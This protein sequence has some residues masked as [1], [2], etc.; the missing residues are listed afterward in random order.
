LRSAARYRLPISRFKEP[1]DGF[2]SAGAHALVA[3]RPAT[4]STKTRLQI[5]RMG[6]IIAHLARQR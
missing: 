3:S 6:G 4:T 2:S 1:A 5:L